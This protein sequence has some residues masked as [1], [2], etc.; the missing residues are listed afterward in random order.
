MNNRPPGIP[1]SSTE[2]AAVRRDRLAAVLKA[3]ANNN[4]IN[5]LMNVEIVY[6]N[7]M[8]KIGTIGLPIYQ[9]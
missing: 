9:N 3:S 1:R 2:K 5:G 6:N 8:V 7:D 4:I